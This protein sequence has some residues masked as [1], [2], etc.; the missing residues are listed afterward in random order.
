MRTLRTDNIKEWDAFIPHVAS[1]IRSATHRTTGFTANKMMLGREVNKPAD[2]VFG[3]DRVNVVVLQP[4]EYVVKLEKILEIVH[5]IAREILG[6]SQQVS[7]NDYDRNL[8]FKLYGVGDLVYEKNDHNP[9]AGISAKLLPRFLGPFVVS[10]VFDT[11]LYVI[12]GRELNN[13]EIKRIVHHNRLEPCRTRESQISRSLKILRNEILSPDFVEPIGVNQ[14]GDP[15]L[16]IK[17]LFKEQPQKRGPKRTS[18]QTGNTTTGTGGSVP[19][20]ETLPETDL[21][22]ET[23]IL[24]DDGPGLTD[25]PNKDGPV[26]E[27]IV[28]LGRTRL[29]PVHDA[30]DETEDLGVAIEQSAQDEELIYVSND[31]PRV[32]TRGRVMRPSWRFKDYVMNVDDLHF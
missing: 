26:V 6:N 23:D 30:T 16:E 32:S 20:V 2:L 9:P 21:P 8:N 29:D 7:K 5:T 11:C 14:T 18:E 24:R 12:R 15:I 19:I 25:L 3:L 27:D 17:K 10:R 4:Y 31:N 28:E 13:K 1:S 22:T